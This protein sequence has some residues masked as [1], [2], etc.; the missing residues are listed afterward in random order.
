MAFTEDLSLFFD[1]AVFAVAAT[2]KNASNVTVRTANVI[3]EKPS[4]L[5]ELFGMEALPSQPYVLAKSTDVTDVRDGWKMVIAG[6]TYRVSGA[7]KAL[8]DGA[9]TAVQLKPTS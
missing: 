4:E 3:L 7:P 8:G 9:V 1:T 2:V 6:I 5:S